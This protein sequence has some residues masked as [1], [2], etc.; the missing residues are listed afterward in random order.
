MEGDSGSCVP[1]SSTAS[2]V[3]RPRLSWEEG[4]LVHAGP[5]PLVSL[6]LNLLLHCQREGGSDGNLSE[7]MSTN[8]LATPPQLHSEENLQGAL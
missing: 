1:V 6:L 2:R 8:S 4:D 7:Q 5:P 3:I